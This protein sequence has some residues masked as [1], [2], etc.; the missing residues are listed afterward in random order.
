MTQRPAKRQG[1][2]WGERHATFRIRHFVRVRALCAHG[3]A[4]AGGAILL[5]PG[6]QERV[7]WRAAAGIGAELLRAA[8]GDRRT[9]RTNGDGRGRIGCHRTGCRGH[10]TVVVGNL[11]GVDARRAH[12]NAL[13]GG[14]ALLGAGPEE[15]VRR[16]AAAG[17][18]TQ[19]R[20]GAG[21]NFH[22]RHRNFGFWIDVDGD[23]AIG[24]ARVVVGNLQRVLTG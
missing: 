23:R 1:D 19:L 15:L 2:G 17:V 3:D 12:I 16:R 24:A 20:R 13:A 21:A 7:R 5:R 4:L 9:G 22:A 10:A 14:A 6:P 8:R 11:V 18:G